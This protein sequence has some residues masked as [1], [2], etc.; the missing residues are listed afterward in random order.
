MWVSQLY[1]VFL[2]SA[3]L[4]PQYCS[5]WGVQLNSRRVIVPA[6]IGFGF[7][8]T[9]GGQAHVAHAYDRQIATEYKLV[10][11]GEMEISMA[12]RAVKRRAMAACKNPAMLK[13]I[14]EKDSSLEDQKTCTQRVIV[15]QDNTGLVK[16]V[17]DAIKDL[18]PAELQALSKKYGDQP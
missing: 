9:D 11:D 3:L 10:R 13:L 5:A 18:P 6:L 2:L 8:A 14:M 17:T 7:S 1:L 16:T 12:P 15:D 4:N